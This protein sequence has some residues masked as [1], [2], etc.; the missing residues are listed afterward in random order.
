M[1][2]WKPLFYI[3]CGNKMGFLKKGFRV[4]ANYCSEVGELKLTQAKGSE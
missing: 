3:V 2:V 4:S 1:L